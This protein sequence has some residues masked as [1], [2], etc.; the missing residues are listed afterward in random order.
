M[1]ADKRSWVFILILSWFSLSKIL[2]KPK[3][4][5]IWGKKNFATIYLLKNACWDTF[6]NYCFYSLLMRHHFKQWIVVLNIPLLSCL[7]VSPT[8]SGT[9]DTSPPPWR[10]LLLFLD[11][12]MVAFCLNLLCWFA[13]LVRPVKLC[14]TNNLGPTR[15][16]QMGYFNIYVS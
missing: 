10:P 3:R 13:L 15:Q 7:I 12:V 4:D 2:Y 6:S 9:D 8:C 5:F 14:P 11:W 16:G 1:Q